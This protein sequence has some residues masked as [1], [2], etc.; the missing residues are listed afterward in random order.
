MLTHAPI[1]L[2]SLLNI[3]LSRNW[4][5]TSLHVMHLNA[6]LV[7]AI[8]PS[9]LPVN[10]LLQYPGIRAEELPV[11]SADAAKWDAEKSR[12]IYVVER[13]KRQNDARAEAI[14]KAGERWGRL[15]IV[16]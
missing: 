2:T 12:L 15:E 13:L 10:N 7:Q 6:Y 4:L 1:L 16:D 3:T 5:N 14:A 11:L 8:K 9:T